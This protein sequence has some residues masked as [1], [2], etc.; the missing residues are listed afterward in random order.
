MALIFLSLGV[1]VGPIASMLRSIQLMKFF[2]RTGWGESQ[3]FIGGDV[4][5][6]L[7]GMCQGNGAAPAAWLVLSSVLVMIYKSLGFGSKMRSPIMRVY[8]DITGVLFVDDTDLYILDECLRTPYDLWHETQ[9]ATNSWGKLL[10]ATG[11]ALKPA[12]CF[13]Y[14]VDY[15]WRDDGS[16]EYSELSRHCSPV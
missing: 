4:M 16:W 6:I 8:L 9:S 11:G 1:G 12:K 14:M 10:L 3:E 7:H 15:E 2:L 5:K 13:Y